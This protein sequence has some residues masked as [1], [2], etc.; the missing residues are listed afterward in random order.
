M[1]SPVGARGVHGFFEIEVVIGG[2][3]TMVMVRRWSG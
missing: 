3:G 2:K 1:V